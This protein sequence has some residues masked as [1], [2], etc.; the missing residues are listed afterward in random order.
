MGRKK[1]IGRSITCMHIYE[2]MRTNY[3]GKKIKE[4][5]ILFDDLV[6]NLIIVTSQSISA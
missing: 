4:M 2:N 3:N 6:D 1:K 5:D